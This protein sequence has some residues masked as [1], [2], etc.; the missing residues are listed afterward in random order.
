MHQQIC[1]NY[2]ALSQH[3]QPSL[4]SIIRVLSVSSFNVPSSTV[5]SHIA[6]PC[7][8]P[9]LRLRA[10]ASSCFQ[11]HPR[12]PL[13]SQALAALLFQFSFRSRIVSIRCCLLSF[14]GSKHHQHQHYFKLHSIQSQQN[15]HHVLLFQPPLFLRQRRCSA[16][17]EPT[18]GFFCY[19]KPGMEWKKEPVNSDVFKACQI[20]FS[21][22]GN[23]FQKSLFSWLTSMTAYCIMQTLGGPSLIATIFMRC[24]QAWTNSAAEEADRGMWPCCWGFT[25]VFSSCRQPSASMCACLSVRVRK[26]L[27]LG[28]MHQPQGSRS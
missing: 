5:T 2:T 15:H 17:L 16:K 20:L 4:Q 22:W 12:P 6:A 14:P 10:S 3:H 7:S 18:S 23:V 13:A 25:G 9:A 28:F 8:M 19:K 1:A 26:G 24:A 11:H 27:S 21:F